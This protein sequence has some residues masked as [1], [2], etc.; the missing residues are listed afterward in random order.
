MERND[1]SH[2]MKLNKVKKLEHQNGMFRNFQKFEISN[3]LL[4]FCKEKL[5]T[6]SKKTLPTENWIIYET[7]TS[8]K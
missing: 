1:Y 4:S 7:H 8:E 5:Y 3:I 2:T 6:K